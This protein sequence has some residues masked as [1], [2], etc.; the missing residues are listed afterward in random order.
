MSF[1]IKFPWT[2]G[3]KLRENGTGV[4]MDNFPTYWAMISLDNHNT[5][6]KFKNVVM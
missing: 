2:M 6:I 3:K 4:C 5:G 1:L